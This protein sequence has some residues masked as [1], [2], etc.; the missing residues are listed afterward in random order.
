M[1]K[2][3]NNLF[4]SKEID[5]IDRLNSIFQKRNEASSLKIQ[6]KEFERLTVEF[7]WKS[8]HIEG[9]TYSL[10]DTERLIKENI[11]EIGHSK[12]ESTIILNHKRALDFIS[13][14]PSYY[15]EIT[16][17]KILELHTLVSQKLGIFQG[18]RMSPVDIIGTKYKP[19]ENQHQINDAMRRFSAL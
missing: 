12:E 15:K 3:L 18:L 1:F 11:E 5:E 8:S 17:S 6:Q 9:N 2:N 10:L 19:L 7:S 13:S 16:L 14:D 4:T